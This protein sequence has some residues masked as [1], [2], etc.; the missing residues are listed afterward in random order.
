MGSRRKKVADLDTKLYLTEKYELSWG[1]QIV[2]ALRNFVGLP[3]KFVEENKF[4]ISIVAEYDEVGEATP[5]DAEYIDEEFLIDDVVNPTTEEIKPVESVEETESQ[6]QAEETKPEKVEPTIS[7]KEEPT[8]PTPAETKEETKPEKVEPTAA[9]TEVETEAK[10]ETEPEKEEVKEEAKAETREIKVSVSPRN[11]PLVSDKNP[12]ETVADA[13]DEPETKTEKEEPT[14]PAPAETKAEE[15]KPEKVEPTAAETEA[16]TKPEKVEPTVA[17]TKAPTTSETKPE[18]PETN[19][20]EDILEDETIADEDIIA[21]DDIFIDEDRLLDEDEATPS[22]TDRPQ[23]TSYD[24]EREGVTFTL[25][26]TDP[27]KFYE[28][29]GGYIDLD[30][31]IVDS[32]PEVDKGPLTILDIVLKFMTT[33]YQ[34]KFTLTRKICNW[35]PEKIQTMMHMAILRVTQP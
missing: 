25:E 1:E 18:E 27:G 6:T 33:V 2:N 24:Y 34:D 31:A 10:V 28:A 7:E 12:D 8:A 20:S 22:N 5:S 35:L 16:E 32:Q 21:E 3:D 29:A 26:K 11:V 15:S 30:G 9:E 17:E 13:T 23:R 19:K 14:A 4:E